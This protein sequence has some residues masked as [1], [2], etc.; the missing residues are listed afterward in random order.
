MH[1]TTLWNLASPVGAILEASPI[2]WLS[3]SS[4]ASR[5]G[6]H[7]VLSHARLSSSVIGLPG[8]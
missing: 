2:T 1:V 3:G 7:R 6:P 4:L 8:R 5:K